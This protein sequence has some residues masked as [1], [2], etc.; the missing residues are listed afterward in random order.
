[1]SGICG[2]WGKDPSE[3]VAETLALIAGG[4]SLHVDERIER[5][6]DVVVRRA[7]V[8]VSPDAHTKGHPSRRVVNPFRRRGARPQG[9]LGKVLMF[10]SGAPRAGWTS[11][12]A[13]PFYDEV[14]D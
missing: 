5:R 7:V 12:P 9:T 13:V 1:M 6:V 14:E 8:S 2:V 10:Q 3:R 11:A 4:L